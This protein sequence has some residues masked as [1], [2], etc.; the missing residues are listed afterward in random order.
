[1]A[2]VRVITAD[3]DTGRLKS[4]DGSYQLARQYDHLS[5][6][7]IFTDA[8]TLENYYLI[9]KMK[10]TED[11][12]PRTMEPI[13][14]AGPSWLIPNTYTQLCQNIAFQVCCKTESGDFE[15][16]SAWFNGVV[17]KSAGHSGSALSVDPS[18]MYEP[19]VAYV[20]ELAAS[21]VAAAGAVVID[22]GLTIQGAAADSKAVGDALDTV[23]G[24]LESL[25]EGG[26]GTTV[27]TEVRQAIY[28]LLDMNA[29]GQNSGASA[30]LAVLQSWAAQVTS[31]TLN[32][33]TASISG[34]NTAQLTA[35]TV[36]TG[37][38]VLWD[39]SDA[40]VATVSNGVVTG[41]GNGTCR[42]T[43]TSGDKHAYC[44]VTVTGFATLSSI[45]AVYTQS[46]TVYNTDSL[47]DL[48]SDLVV[49]GTYSDSTTQPITDY[50][51]AGTL[52]V[53]TSSITVAYRGKTTTFNVTVTQK[54]VGWLYHFENSLASD[55]T[56]DFEW[57][58]TEHYG[59]GYSGQ[60]L[61]HEVGTEGEAN[62]DPYYGAYVT[63]LAAEDIPDFSGDFT[64]SLWGKNV[65]TGRG[66][67]FSAQ[68]YANANQAT[69]FGTLTTDASAAAL[70]WSSAKNSG[71]TNKYRGVAIRWVSSLPNYYVYSSES[72]N[73]VRIIVTPP[74]SFDD[75]QWHHYALTRHDSTIYFFIDGVLINTLTDATEAVYFPDQI[76]VGNAF[77]ESASSVKTRSAY[78]Y[79]FTVD[80][81]Y[82]A[83]SCKW[84]SNFDPSSI[85]Y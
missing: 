53:G 71:P 32:M 59:T 10:E 79:S 45:S 48:R 38:V 8:P 46:G 16:H 7:V 50:T 30:P 75:T 54:P 6:L 33:A 23:N 72:N 24:R 9:V 15:R 66:M 27:P 1:M 85:V 29:F 74:S 43:A 36:P 78:G 5:N 77:G 41:V 55:G 39:T 26:T 56:R 22:S 62:T 52:T 18:S 20:Q 13:R 68:K 35:T 64:V 37:S 84:T 31:V 49:T 21:L 80:D 60:G 81:L 17:E 11:G 28:S 42:I 44:D 3:W 58:G 14:L 19:Y 12:Q 69:T 82:I 34:P 61:F 83:E 73:G 4:T 65:T 40:S 47:D 2:N 57:S 67:Y 63:D 76:S 51:L 70:G 25:E